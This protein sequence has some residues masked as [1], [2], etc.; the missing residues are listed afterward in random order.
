[1][2]HQFSCRAHLRKGKSE[3]IEFLR[4]AHRNISNRPEHRHDLFGFNIK[5]EHGLCAR[6]EVFQHH[7]RVH[8]K[9]PDVFEHRRTLDVASEES[10]ER[11]FKT[12][13]L[14][15]ELYNVGDK[16]FNLPHSKNTSCGFC[17]SAEGGIHLIALLYCGLP[18][19]CEYVPG[20]CRVAAE[21]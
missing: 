4:V 18:D 9:F 7:G 16:F 1:M 13:N 19:T 21:L 12:F 2:T 17:Y 6:S 11:D 5:S 3:G 8:G 10:V 20:F 15:T 14:S